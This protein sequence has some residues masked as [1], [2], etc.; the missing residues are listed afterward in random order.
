MEYSSRPGTARSSLDR[1]ESVFAAYGFD[2]WTMDR[3]NY[4]KS[5]RTAGNSDFA[6][7]A[8]DPARVL[9]KGEGSPTLAERAEQLD[10]YRAHNTR[11]RGREMIRGI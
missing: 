2:V 10:Y 11:L 1:A 4:G 9:H 8:G 6:T 3:D 7:G 5:S